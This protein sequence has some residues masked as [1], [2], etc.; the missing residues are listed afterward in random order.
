MW[1]EIYEEGNLQQDIQA[2]VLEQP[3]YHYDE[4]SLAAILPAVQAFIAAAHDV[5][6]VMARLLELLVHECPSHSFQVIHRQQLL[7][8]AHPHRPNIGY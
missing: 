4:G 3:L 2:I 8:C 5:V 6:G 7:K 1:L